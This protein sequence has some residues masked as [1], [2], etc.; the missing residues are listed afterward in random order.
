MT[1]RTVTSKASKVDWS[2]ASGSF[3][4]LDESKPLPVLTVEQ[5]AKGRRIA[6]FFASERADEIAI[7][8]TVRMRGG[9]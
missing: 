7:A 5:E 8:N 9:K 1:K 3:G 2:A 6:A 4:N